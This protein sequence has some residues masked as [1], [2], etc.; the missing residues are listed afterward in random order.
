MG[1]GDLGTHLHSPDLVFET[2][3]VIASHNIISPDHINMLSQTH[4][5]LDRR[6]SGRLQITPQVIHTEVDEEICL[7]EQ[8][9]SPDFVI[10]VHEADINP[11]HQGVKTK[12]RDGVKEIDD[13]LCNF[14]LCDRPKWHPHDFCGNTHA[15]MAGAKAVDYDHKEKG[16]EQTHT[17]NNI[18]KTCTP[19]IYSQ[20]FTESDMEQKENGEEGEKGTSDDEPESETLARVK[21]IPRR[22]L[23]MEEMTIQLPKP[24]TT[25]EKIT[26]VPEM[27]GDN[28]ESCMTKT[29]ELIQDTINDLFSTTEK[30]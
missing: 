18:T 19:I 4:S 28:L 30:L 23:F 8:A 17:W 13:T 20:P 16:I 1:L 3:D 7:P 2:I 10:T 27:H 21:R 22:S 12:V 15:M 6:L 14:P 9:T 25:P 24:H 26:I 5:T 11:Q 29:Q